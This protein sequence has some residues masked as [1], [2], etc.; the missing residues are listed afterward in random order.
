MALLPVDEHRHALG[1]LVDHDQHLGDAGSA[2]T[3]PP[4]NAIT[5]EMAL[6]IG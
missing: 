5:D 3:M 4:S 6:R 1:R 2:R